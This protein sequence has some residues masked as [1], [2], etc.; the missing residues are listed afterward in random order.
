VPDSAAVNPRSSVL[1]RCT[2]FGT[3]SHAQPAVRRPAWDPTRFGP[4]TVLSPDG[5]VNQRLPSIGGCRSGIQEETP[6][7]ALP[8]EI[9]WIVSKSGS[10]HARIDRLG[11]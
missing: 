10:C 2:Q 3:S 7:T 1:C 6:R 9:L 4:P 5:N 8:D 11:L